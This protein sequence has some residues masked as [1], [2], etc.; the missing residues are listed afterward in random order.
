LASIKFTSDCVHINYDISKVSSPYLPQL[1][2][3]SFTFAEF[4]MQIILRRITDLVDIRRI[5]LEQQITLVSEE[6]V[7][8]GPGFWCVID[9]T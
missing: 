8:E 7:L 1:L 9:F 4:D 6:V 2:F 5:E 3:L